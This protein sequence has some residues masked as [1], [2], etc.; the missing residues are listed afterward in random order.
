MAGDGTLR[1][2][3]LTWNNGGK[4]VDLSEPVHDGKGVE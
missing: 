1:L 2:E 4:V 3:L